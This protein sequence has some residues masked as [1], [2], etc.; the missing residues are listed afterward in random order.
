M[1]KERVPDRADRKHVRTFRLG[2]E[3]RDDLTGV[4]TAEERL[5]LLRELSERAWALSGRPFPSYSRSQIPV[6]VTHLR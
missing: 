3:P 5:L 4:M 6:R 2:E 1:A